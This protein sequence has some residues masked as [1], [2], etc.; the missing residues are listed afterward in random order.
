MFTDCTTEL[1]EFS[2]QST[3]ELTELI[4]DYTADTAKQV[5]KAK[6][7]FLRLMEA[8]LIKLHGLTDLDGAEKKA[9]KDAI[10]TQR[11]VFATS[12][13]NWSMNIGIKMGEINTGIVDTGL[14]L[15]DGLQV[16]ITA[17]AG[18]FAAE[19]NTN[20]IDCLDSP[21]DVK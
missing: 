12:V 17:K 21:S 11:S 15:E 5:N 19:M 18:K 9:L 14:T 2:L 6:S 16:L 4:A 7:D 8:T 10:V 1:S 13:M 3:T 20:D